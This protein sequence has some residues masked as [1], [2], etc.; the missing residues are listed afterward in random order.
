MITPFVPNWSGDF[1]ENPEVARADCISKLGSAFAR[2]Y[3]QTNN[4]ITVNYR[5]WKWHN[6]L[7]KTC[8]GKGQQLG[9]HTFLLAGWVG[10]TSKRLILENGMT[11]LLT[12]VTNIPNSFNDWLSWKCLQLS[13][14]AFSL[15]LCIVFFILSRLFIVII[16]T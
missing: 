10:S 14:D 6:K 5:F 9:H 11:V 4:M 8:S 3:S 7:H 15:R 12:L 16:F 1:S 13:L 2:Q